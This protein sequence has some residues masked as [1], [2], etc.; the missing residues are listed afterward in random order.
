MR[1][2]RHPKKVEKKKIRVNAN[3]DIK[4]TE[5]RVLDEN[6]EF[7]GIMP[8]SDALA[9]SDERGYDLIE[10]SPNAVPPVC[11]FG[12]VGKYIYEQEK[13]VRKQKKLQKKTGVK[14][15]RLS[16]KISQHDKD[17]RLNQGIKFLQQGNKLK[18]ESIL[19]GRERQFVNLAKEKMQSF[20]NDLQSQEDLNIVVEQPVKMVGNQ[21]SAIVFHKPE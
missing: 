8:T 10:I 3:A 18:V 7:L 21:I 9:L 13:K 5:V 20:V 15:L 2:K 12:T 17:V 11:R 4:A 14:T 6:G 19:R 16:Y 1:K